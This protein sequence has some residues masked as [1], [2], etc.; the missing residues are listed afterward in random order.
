MDHV[1]GR[2]A[3][4][5]EAHRASRRSELDSE[6]CSPSASTGRIGSG[7]YDCFGLRQARYPMTYM[8][9]R[10]RR[11]W[12]VPSAGHTTWT[13]L[14]TAG[15]VGILWETSS[16]LQGRRRHASS[17]RPR[18]SRMLPSVQTVGGTSAR[19]KQRG[20]GRRRSGRRTTRE[21]TQTFQDQLRERR[22]RELEA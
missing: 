15:C 2:E 19:P 4:P 3:P 20:S 8:R 17:A 18:T 13:A 21:P 16:S 22:G 5:P 9:R 14:R 1:N 10:G 11:S 6:S 12:I 7:Q